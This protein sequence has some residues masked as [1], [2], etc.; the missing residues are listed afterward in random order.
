VSHKTSPAGAASCASCSVGVIPPYSGWTQVGEAAATLCEAPFLLMAAAWIPKTVGL[1]CD[2]R[3]L[4]L[5][6]AGAPPPLPELPST[7]GPRTH[8]T[9][10]HGRWHPEHWSR[11]TARL[12]NERDERADLGPG[13]RCR[14][15]TGRTAVPWRRS[16]HRYSARMS[17]KPPP[18]RPDPHPVPMKY[19]AHR[20]PTE[21]ERGRPCHYAALPWRTS[22]GTAPISTDCAAGPL[23]RRG[24]TRGRRKGAAS[25]C[26][27]RP[28]RT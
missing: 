2:L 11:L 16:K 3:S 27:E 24:L 19:R 21:E 23:T 6:G 15:R 17:R 9:P 13:L 10:E 26:S 22:D 1:E 28:P 7:R 8:P 4:V 20:D 5:V 18:V 25:C 14:H 12:R